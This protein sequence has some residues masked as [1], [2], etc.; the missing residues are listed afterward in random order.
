MLITAVA[1]FVSAC[2]FDRHSSNR[3]TA[4]TAGAKFSGNTLEEMVECTRRI[5][6]DPVEDTVVGYAC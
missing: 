4:N 1:A 5:N 6:A 2:V 3:Y